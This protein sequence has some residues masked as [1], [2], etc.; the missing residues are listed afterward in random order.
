VSVGSATT[1]T[2]TTPAHAAG[3]VDVVVFNPD[4]QS[5][6]LQG[7]SRMSHGADHHLVKPAPITQ[8]TPLSAVQLNATANVPG[9]SGCTTA[10]CSVVGVGPR[11]I[12]VGDVQRPTDSSQLAPWR[13]QRS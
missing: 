11:Q 4:A 8:G 5:G 9:D 1:I 6:L 13:R 2:A 7:D 10:A 3:A 12:A